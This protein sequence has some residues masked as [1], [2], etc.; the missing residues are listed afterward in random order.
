[1]DDHYDTVVIT[2]GGC[3][4]GTGSA[5]MCTLF[6]DVL[7][8]VKLYF[9]YNRTFALCK[10][11]PSL[12]GKRVI[13]CD[14]SFPV[15]TLC[16][17]A[18][19]ASSI[20]IWDHHISTYRDLFKEVKE[21]VAKAEFTIAWPQCG[22]RG[23]ESNSTTGYVLEAAV[24]DS[25]CTLAERY[26]WV[27]GADYIYKGDD[28][29]I[30]TNGVVLPAAHTCHIGIALNM[31]LCGTEIVFA[32]LCK[33]RTYRY[34]SPIKAAPPPVPWY[35]K[36]IRDRDLWLWDK[37]GNIA[38]IHYDENSRAFGEAFF[39]LQ[40]HTATL[41]KF[42]SYTQEE[43]QA[44]YTR[45]RALIEHNA[46]IVKMFV[47]KS[48]RVLLDGHPALVAESPVLQSEIGNT[49]VGYVG[50]AAPGVV[51][52]V[53]VVGIVIRYNLQDKCWNV[54]LRGRTGSPDLSAVAKKFG[55]GGHPLAA[56]FD[57][58]G[59]INDI[60]VDAPADGSKGL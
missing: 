11:M 51:P 4:D 37:P 1:M 34:L 59:N 39:E 47:S 52:F 3:A 41:Q 2:H 43:I 24:R 17:I 8:V 7:G 46:R 60:L 54:S 20:F 25:G 29:F 32:E 33:W 13:I 40:I 36:H 45:G 55:G 14:Y 42:D 27:G 5:H 35:I 10:G 6:G 26:E 58:V 48:S 23:N 50:P 9:S 31:D 28:V 38:G 12:E 19:T 57:Y 30:R 22:D 15:D 16:E 53:P 44:L 18:R 21:S 56:G 49:L